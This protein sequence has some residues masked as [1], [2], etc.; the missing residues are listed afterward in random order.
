EVR[1]VGAFE[2]KPG[3]PASV[4]DQLGPERLE[5]LCLGE[6]YHPGE[7]RRKIERI[8]VVRIRKQLDPQDPIGE[9]I[10]D[11]WRVFPCPP[12]QAGCRIEFQDPD[13]DPRR[14]NIYY[15]RAIQEPTPTVNGSPLRCERDE[16]GNCI[17]ARGC[18]VSGPRF[19]PNDPCLSDA[20]ERAWS[21]PI[22]VRV[23]PGRELTR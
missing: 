16:H 5:R 21:S 20:Q 12:S 10:E 15:V 23:E 2:Q 8:E 4:K 14:E 9:L 1:A 6:C 7:S 22:F 17:R 13:P 3:C 11:P 19:D 18:P